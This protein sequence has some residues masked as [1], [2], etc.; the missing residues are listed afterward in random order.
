MKIHLRIF[1]FCFLTLVMTVVGAHG[2]EGHG[3][4]EHSVFSWD[5]LLR[6][7][8]V[9]EAFIEDDF[10]LSLGHERFAPLSCQSASSSQKAEVNRGNEKRER[11]L[12]NCASATGNSHWCQQLVRPNPDSV[13]TF[14]C[15]YGSSQVHQ[16]I[17]PDEG[18]WNYAFRAVGLIEDLE[19]QG[20]SVCRIYNWWRPEPYNANV[21]G[22]PGRHPYGTSVDVQFCSKA[23]QEKAFHLLCQHRRAGRLRALGYYS[24]TSLHFGVGDNV[25][26]TWGKSCP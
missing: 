13:S 7:G 4:P 3:D 12:N 26:N 1:G 21:G 16:L 11:F 17:H 6:S 2:H 15:T 18:T 14:R 8:Q 24:S 19:S 9:N 20:V 23:D 5:E 22:A 25:A 10:E